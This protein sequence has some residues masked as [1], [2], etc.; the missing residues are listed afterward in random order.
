MK[1]LAAMATITMMSLT[2]LLQ[3]AE[4][5]A[6]RLSLDQLVTKHCHKKSS[7]SKPCCYDPCTAVAGSFFA[8]KCLQHCPQKVFQ[9][10]QSC[11]T[12]IVHFPGTNV[13]NGVT[14]CPSGDAIVVPKKGIYKIEWNASLSPI[15]TNNIYYHFDLQKNGASLLHPTP[16]VNGQVGYDTYAGNTESAA[17]SVIVP[18]CSNDEITLLLTVDGS[19]GGIGGVQIDSAQISATWISPICKS[20]CHCN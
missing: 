3:G 14:L 9:S 5:K 11:F 12:A 6:E 2:S 19:E 1:N 17:A 18:L 15:D 7:S 8:D 4:K 16:Q 10:G 20:D 13:E